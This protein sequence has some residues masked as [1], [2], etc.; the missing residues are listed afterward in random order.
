MKKSK[1]L[2]VILVTAFLLSSSAL[3]SQTTHAQGLPQQP[4]LTV[5]DIRSSG[6]QICYTV[7]NAGTGSL[8]SIKEPAT[9][10]NALFIDNM[11]QPVE[12]DQVDI[13]LAPGA[14]TERC[15]SYQWQMTPPQDT[16]NVCTDWGQNMIVESDEKNNCLQEVWTQDLPDLIVD[17]IECGPGSKL[18]LTVKNT[19]SAALPAGWTA[20]ADVY[21][22]QQHLGFFN[23]GSPTSTTGGGIGSPGGSSYYLL[24]WDI[25]CLLYTS[26]SPR[27]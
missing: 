8:G 10:F 20:L 6:N 16:V 24:G 5:T 19:G 11:Q 21:F 13:Y 12:T 23:L 25:I 27:D 9:F 4:D 22:N 7:K 14:Q 3:I 15:F 1:M 18:A 2:H 17:K 26:P